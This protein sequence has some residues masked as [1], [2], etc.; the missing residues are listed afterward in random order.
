MGGSSGTGSTGATGGSQFQLPSWLTGG[1]STPS[2]GQTASTPSATPSTPGF[3]PA[4]VTAPGQ[5]QQSNMG[6]PMGGA[7]NW[8][9]MSMIMWQLMSGG[10]QQPSGSGGLYGGMAGGMPDWIK[11]FSQGGGGVGGP[12]AAAAPAPQDLTTQAYTPSGYSN[13]LWDPS[14][15]LPKP[16]A[17]TPAAPAAAA[18]QKPAGNPWDP[19]YGPEPSTNLTEIQK[20]MIL[21]GQIPTG[22]DQSTKDWLRWKLGE[23]G[24][25]HRISSG[26]VNNAEGRQDAWNKYGGPGANTGTYAGVAPSGYSAHQ[27]YGA[28]Q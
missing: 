18:P 19:M 3:L 27:W 23:M 13:S 5:A 7:P 12:P 14:Q 22:Q 11:M 4:G 17:P 20:K 21:S 25:T 1:P 28:Y 2:G 26:Y 16:V 15:V 8:N 10:M 6:F 24:Y 9:P